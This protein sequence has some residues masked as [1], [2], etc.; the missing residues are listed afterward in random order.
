MS[1]DNE[2]YNK[3]S[4]SNDETGSRINQVSKKRKTFKVL[5]FL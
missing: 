4:S 3:L 5:F 2:V 1:G